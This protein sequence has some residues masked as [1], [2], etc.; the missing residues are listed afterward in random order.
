MVC[1]DNAM[2]ID[3]GYVGGVCL[4]TVLSQIRSVSRA[5]GVVTVGH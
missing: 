5:E 1:K 3:G 2:F 4:Q